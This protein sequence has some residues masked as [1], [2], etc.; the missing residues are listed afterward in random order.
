MLQG[1][2]Q[3]FF[4]LLLCG[5]LRPVSIKR[6]TFGFSH[7]IDL[8]RRLLPILICQRRTHTH[9]HTLARFGFTL[10]ASTCLCHKRCVI[11]LHVAG[12][13]IM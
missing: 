4:L 1:L 11:L 10:R 2:S 7:D 6:N 5:E 13:L 12:G 3:T 8:N 9:T